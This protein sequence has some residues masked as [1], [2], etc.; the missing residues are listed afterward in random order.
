MLAV[1]LDGH[2]ME[3]LLLAEQVPEPIR[4][5]GCVRSEV[6]VALAGLYDAERGLVFR[7]VA[8]NSTQR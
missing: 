1:E 7:P 5:W 2:E 4:K 8:A 3:F 6:F